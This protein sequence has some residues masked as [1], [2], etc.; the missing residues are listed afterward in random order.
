MRRGAFASPLYLKFLASRCRLS[1]SLAKNASRDIELDLLGESSSYAGSTSVLRPLGLGRGLARLSDCEMDRLGVGRC[2]FALEAK[3]VGLLVDFTGDRTSVLAGVRV[4]RALSVGEPL[5]TSTDFLADATPAFLGVGEACVE[6]CF[7]GEPVAPS[8]LV[9]VLFL[10]GV[11]GCRCATISS[12]SVRSSGSGESRFDPR[13]EDGMWVET[14]DKH[15][16]NV[17]ARA[18]RRRLST[19]LAQYPDHVALPVPAH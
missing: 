14:I 13:L 18:S 8:R 5:A 15:C 1:A 16:R 19:R 9:R 17:T 12:P 2:F 10:T 7:A 4:L 3:V 6:V 11:D